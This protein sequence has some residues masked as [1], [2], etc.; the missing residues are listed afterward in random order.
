MLYLL[1]YKW[2][3]YIQQHQDF[4]AQDWC[5]NCTW[6]III[7]YIYVD[8]VTIVNAQHK[9]SSLMH[10]LSLS[11]H[12]HIATL[13]DEFWLVRTQHNYVNQDGG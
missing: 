4:N 11:L 12:D 6:E 2:S 7:A 13:L 10:D 8:D 1:I 9:I 3:C 5:Y